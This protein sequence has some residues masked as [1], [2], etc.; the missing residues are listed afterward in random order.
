[1]DGELISQQE[2]VSLDCDEDMAI[3]VFVEFLKENKAISH[4]FIEAVSIFQTGCCTSCANV[5][6]LTDD[7]NLN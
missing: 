6:K 4:I 3:S 7:I 5:S 2:E 1:L